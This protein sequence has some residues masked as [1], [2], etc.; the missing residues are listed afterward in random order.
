MDIILFFY[1]LTYHFLSTSFVF[2]LAHA[3]DTFINEAVKNLYWEFLVQSNCFF[4]FLVH[5][6]HVSIIISPQT[7]IAIQ[8]T[9]SSTN[10]GRKMEV[11]Q[12]QRVV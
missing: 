3:S 11:T 6:T 5:V 10:I 12:P 2:S 4:V 8:H 1:R 9:V 7:S